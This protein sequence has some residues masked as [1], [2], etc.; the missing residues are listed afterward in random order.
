M[1]ILTVPPQVVCA[2]GAIPLVD[3]SEFCH[4][5][6][7]RLGGQSRLLA[8]FVK[9]G[10]DPSLKELHAV[11]ADDAHGCIH[12]MRT[13]VGGSYPAITNLSAG[14]H[15][16][17]R[18]IYE[19]WGIEPT[20]HPW[21]K[22]VRYPNDSSNPKSTV[23]IADFYTMTGPAIHEVAVGPVHAG[24]IEPGHFRF[25]C[26]GEQV[27][28]LEISL[29]YQ[30]RGIDRAF[31]QVPSF[32]RDSYVEVIAGDTSIG[33]ATAYAQIIEALAEVH[34]TE[35]SYAIRA[36]ALEL[37]RLANHTGDL[38]ALAGDVGFLP[39]SAYCGALRGDFLNLTAMLCGSRL[40]R[41]LIRPGGV[42][43]GVDNDL[44]VALQKRLTKIGS[45]VKGAIELL[46]ETPSVLARFEH[47]GTLSRSLC[48]DFGFV[49]PVARSC[50]ISSDVRQDFAFGYYAKKSMAAVTSSTCD[51]Y[52]RAVVKWLEMQSSL[53]MI[54]DHDFIAD[55][56]QAKIGPLQPDACCVS[57]VEGW[58]GE[59]C[60]LA[61]T[62]AR[63]ELSFYKI[64]DPSMHNWTALALALRG[65]EISD[66]PLCN[67]SFNLSYCGHDL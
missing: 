2:T 36:L 61:F 47:T 25:Q 40:G 53:A 55:R 5:L 64:I 43:H 49:G 27:L 54:R 66:F 46:F 15:Y 10:E 62:D 60:H 44:Q 51:V 63:G 13:H 26:H 24:V 14:A 4:E 32:R 29:G 57:L 6:T 22:P 35:G 20:G 31:L 59:I 41:S 48:R 9:E 38:G 56:H 19:R 1:N 58:R 52:G 65:Q 30:H 23:G 34:P 18:E 3:M 39:T 67:K 42:R 21:L 28:H 17:E 7:T 16:F 33:H 8:L 37:E 11:M 45:Q 12:L 50:G